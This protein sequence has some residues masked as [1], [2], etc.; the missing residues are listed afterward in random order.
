MSASVPQEKYCSISE[1]EGRCLQC[2]P[3]PQEGTLSP[4]ILS[5]QHT[6][7]AAT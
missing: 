3:V 2:C 5:R 1:H 7:G 6:S 4:H